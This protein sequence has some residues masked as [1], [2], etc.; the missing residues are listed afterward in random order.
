MNKKKTKFLIVGIV[1]LAIITRLM[2][3]VAGV[4]VVATIY[5]LLTSDISHLKGHKKIKW[6][7]SF[8]A[9]LSIFFVAISARVFL[10]EIFAIPSGSMEETLLPGDKILVNKLDYGPR[11]PYSPY[12]IPWI[13][14]FW[15]LKANAATNTDT[16]YWNYNRLRG[17]SK[18]RNGDVLVFGHPLWGKRDNYFIKRCIGI[19]GDTLVIKLGNITINGKPFI[20]P[21]HVRKDFTI[22]YNNRNQLAKLSDSLHINNYGLNHSKEENKLEIPLFM[23]QLDALLSSTCIDSIRVKEIPKDPNHWARPERSDFNWTINDYGPIT[24][25]YKGMKIELN[26][27]NFM[28]YWQTIERLEKVKLEERNGRYFLDNQAARDYTFKS[29][30]YFMM[31]DNRNNSNDSRYWGF[32]PEENVVGK[33]VVILF[34]NNDSGVQWKR[35]LKPIN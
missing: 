2:W 25:P 33:A 26:R 6:L 19:A 7:V 34:S 31:G 4:S 9:F 5:L 23:Y 24:V 14:L 35:I 22:W 10:I 13:N 1:L 21:G 12:E 15:F 28:R 27:T 17:Y 8:I 16:I 3:L 32:V 11:L 18:I 29:N 20:E 30:Y